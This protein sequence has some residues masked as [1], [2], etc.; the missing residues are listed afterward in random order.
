MN[1]PKFYRDRNFVNFE[2]SPFDRMIAF[3]Y[4][5][6]PISGVIY[7][8]NT[9]HTYLFKVIT[10]D[11]MQD[12]RLYAFQDIA[13]ELIQEILPPLL[14][15]NDRSSN[16]LWLLSQND[17]KQIDERGILFQLLESWQQIDS[18]AL[19]ESHLKSFSEFLPSKR[20]SLVALD[21]IRSDSILSFSEW[22]VEAGLA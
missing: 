5:D 16:P 13:V 19:S 20:E 14:A 9:L 12:L 7:N 1:I 15:I 3:K 22:S 2:T 10:W 21:I 6:G 18:L 17:C 11:E 8:S 4:Y